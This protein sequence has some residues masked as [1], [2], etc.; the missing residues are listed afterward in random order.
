MHE[1]FW[2]SN[3]GLYLLPPDILARRKKWGLDIEDKAHSAPLSVIGNAMQNNKYKLW[4]PPFSLQAGPA[5]WKA[6]NGRSFCTW[7]FKNVTSIARDYLESGS[8]SK[9]L[10]LK[11]SEVRTWV[12]WLRWEG[13]CDC[14]FLQDK[15]KKFACGNVENNNKQL[16]HISHSVLHSCHPIFLFRSLVKRFGSAAHIG[17]SELEIINILS[18]FIVDFLWVEV[19]IA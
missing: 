3:K 8:F 1:N 17:V 2:R 9:L 16:F 14:F 6:N 18:S 13:K 12:Q 7:N 10:C 15:R 5:S 11:L 4:Q 19:T